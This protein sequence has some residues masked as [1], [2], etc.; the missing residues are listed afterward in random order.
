MIYKANNELD[1][2]RFY[3]A[4]I[5]EMKF[6]NHLMIWTVSS[7]NAMATNTQND[8]IKDMCIEATMTFECTSIKELKFSAYKV[9]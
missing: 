2:F 6:I 4:E 1:R 3:N 9:M 8:I 5:K 7:L